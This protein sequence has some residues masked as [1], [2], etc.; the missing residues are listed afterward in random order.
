[1]Y[2]LL[3]LIGQLKR[4]AALNRNHKKTSVMHSMQTHDQKYVK[5]TQWQLHAIQ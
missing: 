2:V 4:E 1:V 3:L 5:D